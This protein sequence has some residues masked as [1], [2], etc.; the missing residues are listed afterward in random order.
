MN[1]VHPTLASVLDTICPPKQVNKRP[2]CPKGMYEYTHYTDIGELVCWID[3]SRAEPQTH[4]EPGSPACADCT[5]VW[6]GDINIFDGLG[7]DV[8]KEIEASALAEITS[9]PDDYYTPDDD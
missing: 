2:K 7:D 8:V 6:L 4:W 5:D 9:E 1:A 3:Y